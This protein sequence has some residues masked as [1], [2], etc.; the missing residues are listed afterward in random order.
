MVDW[1]DLLITIFTIHVKEQ[2]SAILFIDSLD[3][4][5][6]VNMKSNISSVVVFQKYGVDVKLIQNL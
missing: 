3:S 1:M 5:N 2:V 6:I 4:V